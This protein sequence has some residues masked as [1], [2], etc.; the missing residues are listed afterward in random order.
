VFKPWLVW[1]LLRLQTIDLSADQVVLGLA[2]NSIALQYGL[3]ACGIAYFEDLHRITGSFTQLPHQLS[4]AV[5]P[6]CKLE[7]MLSV[8]D[9][10]SQTRQEALRPASCPAFG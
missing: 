9:A 5:R 6:V 8:A 7:H 1:V 4:P 2:T 3:K 10:F